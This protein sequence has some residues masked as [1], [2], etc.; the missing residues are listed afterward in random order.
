MS[1]KLINI[2][3]P[4]NELNDSAKKKQNRLSFK[5]VWKIFLFKIMI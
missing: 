2:F 5:K 1:P 3:E 4:Y